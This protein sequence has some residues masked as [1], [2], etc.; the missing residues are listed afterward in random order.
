MKLAS[1]FVIAIAVGL[2]AASS[3]TVFSNVKRSAASKHTTLYALEPAGNSKSDIEIRLDN[4]I[5]DVKTRARILQES[6]SE[7]AGFKQSVAN[8]MAGDYDVLA[9]QREIKELVSSSPC[10]MFTWEASPYCKKAV[11]AMELLGIEQDVKI[12]RLD[13]PWSKGNPIRAELGKMVG[14]T[15][16]PFIFIGGSY[17]GGYDGGTSENAPGM[18]EM[19]FKGTLIPALREAGI[20]V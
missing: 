1:I 8:V 15:S 4:I 18:V 10:V 2:P 13:D 7:G 5:S 20:R 9:V 19:A 3:F 12:V 14:R 11:E 17:V 16:V 6:T